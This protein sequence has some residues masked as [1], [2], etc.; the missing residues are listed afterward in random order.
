MATIERRAYKER[1]D[2]LI[3]AVRKRRK[4]V[5]M[6]ALEHKGGRCEICGYSRCPEALEFHHL[7]KGGKDFG[8]SDKGYTRSWDKIQAEIN[9]CVLLCSNCHREIH[10][11]IAKLNV[12]GE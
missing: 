11:G 7:E 4:K 8:L 1:R 5:R 10:L 6:M 2:Y 12:G 9:K 3:D